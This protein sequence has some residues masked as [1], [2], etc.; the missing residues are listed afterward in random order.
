MKN[1]MVLFLTC[2]TFVS[3]SYAELSPQELTSK[4]ID[5]YEH[6]SIGADLFPYDWFVRLKSA[7]ANELNKNWD[8]YFKDGL[9][10]RASILYDLKDDYESEFLSGVKGLSVTW[11]GNG[12]KNKPAL[13]TDPEFKKTVLGQKAPIRIQNGNL[14]I[15]MLGTNCAACHTGTLQTPNNT[16]K[17]IGGQ[18]NFSID[19]LLKDMIV[20]TLNLFFNVDGQLAEFL[21]TFGYEKGE[22]Y[23]IARRFKKETIRQLRLKPLVLLALKK[24][25]IIKDIPLHTFVKEEDVIANRLKE[26]LRLTLHLK[27][28]QQL[29]N[30]L[31]KRMDF[32]AMLVSGTPRKT[33]QD[34]HWKKYFEVSAGYG[35]VDA[36]NNAFNKLLRNKNEKINLTAAIGYPPIWGIQNKHLMHYTGNTNSVLNRNVGVTMAAG[37]VFLDDQ[38]N[39]TV[40]F[41]NLHQL[42]NIMYKIE[43]PQWEKTFTKEMDPSFKINAERVARGKEIFNN[44]C[45]KCH[46]PVAVHTKF[47]NTLYEYKR[48]SHDVLGTDPN[49]AINIV[50]PIHPLTDA[51]SFPATRY[52]DQTQGII[53]AFF[54]T[55]EIPKELQD[56]YTFKDYRGDDVWF[57]DVNL[58]YPGKTYI[59]RDLAGIWATAPFLHNNSV[60]TLWDLLQKP[61]QRPGLFRVKRRL[62]DPVKVGL[63]DYD[64][65]LEEC[66]YRK[67]NH[68]DKY[69]C[70]CTSAPGNS[71]AGH[72]FGTDLS[73]D[74]KFDLIEYLK[75]LKPYSHN[76]NR[77]PASSKASPETPFLDAF[78]NIFVG[79]LPIIG[80]YLYRKDFLKHRLLTL[81]KWVLKD[82]HQMFRELRE[83]R[84]I[85]FMS[86]LPIKSFGAPNKG[87][88]LL[89]KH[90]DIVEAL[91]NPKVFSAR[92]VGYKLDPVGGHMLGTDETDFNNI[93]KPWL[94]KLITQADYQRIYGLIETFTQ[95][96][97]ALIEKEQSGQKTYEMNLVTD[98]GKRVPALLFEKYFGFSGDS[99]DDLYEWSYWIQMDTFRNPSNKK[100]MRSTALAVEKDLLNKM[101]VYI[102]K[103]EQDLKNNHNK[104]INDTILER[105]ILSEEVQSG[106]IKKDRI[107]INMIGLVGA[108]ID[109][110]Q[111]A[112]VKSLEFFIDHPEQMRTAKEL[113]LQKNYQALQKHVMESLRLHPATPMLLRYAEEDY[114]IAKGTAREALIPKGTSVLL[115]IYS[116]MRDDNVVSNPDEFR[117]DRPEDHYF[118]FGYGHHK[119][120]GDRLATIELSIM[121]AGILQKPNLVYSNFDH[122]KAPLPFHRYIEFDAPSVK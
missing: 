74:A 26:L 121:L 81:K 80:D 77:E 25:K 73:D 45:A 79:R 119:C 10:E 94:R 22:A 23:H 90:T 17:I 82:P 116:A 59:P 75:V 91:N 24:Y 100:K 107:A 34:G 76:A 36:F 64:E 28:D 86:R 101:N 117:L 19:W 41:D 99:I 9:D 92:H 72:N 38:D 61:E 66:F 112:L 68:S 57:K 16:Y 60:P 49:L 33:F 1:S 20:S 83:H 95:E 89:S 8:T 65:N 53:N 109:T 12:A 96:S 55:Y 113:A 14:S 15:R 69:Q 39:T 47:K 37:A 21:E 50:K 71:N 110:V 27:T 98:L 84:P 48:I 52:M 58:E 102:D 11:S 97:F 118:L 108:A 78:D 88:V 70:V 104:P 40:H 122:K 42:E 32:I 5:Q 87:V 103:L 114:T 54:K 4:E 30:E 13:K 111:V 51:T 63:K 115:G 67:G 18:S 44:R 2:F 56:I 46:T 6:L 43:A 31:E 3:L 62:F 120:A 106:K 35:R 93:E 7:R 29:G 85:A 105:M